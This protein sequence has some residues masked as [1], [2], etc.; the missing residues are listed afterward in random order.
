MGTRH[1][2][3]TRPNTGS[4]PGVGGAARQPDEDSGDAAGPSAPQPRSAPQPAPGQAP[5]Q[6]PSPPAA[7]WEID[8]RGTAGGVAPA[9]LERWEAAYRQMAVDARRMGVPAYAIPELPPSPSAEQLRA[10]RDRLSG[11]LASF[12]S[13]G[14]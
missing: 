13:A 6:A 3:V 8:W 10:A 4:P 5:A 2:R 12:L 11:L 14:L 1:T 9:T 7:L